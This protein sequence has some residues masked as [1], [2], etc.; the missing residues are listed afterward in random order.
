[1]SYGVVRVQK[2]TAGSV[3]GIEI[4]D[5]REKDHSHTNPDIDWSR[6]GENY[7]LHPAQNCNFRQAVN[8]RINQLD[9]Q[10]AV[11]KDA[12]V[13]AQI[14]VTSDS[15]FFQ[16]L[17]YSDSVANFDYDMMSLQG[18]RD[19][20]RQFFEDS[21]NFLRDRY[22]MENV[23]SAT[24]HMDE[25]TPHMHFN[26]VPVTADGRLSAKS[27]LTK[28]SLTEQQTAFYEN[29]GKNYD[30]MRGEP[31]ES[32]K[33]RSHLETAEFK[34]A[35][36]EVEDL[37]Q[38]KQ[39]LE[40]D[41]PAMRQEASESR[42]SVSDAREGINTL[43]AKKAALTGEINALENKK[44]TL[45]SNEVETISG[46]RTLTGGLKGVT[47]AEYEALKKTAAQVDR[48][49]KERNLALTKAVKAENKAAAAVQGAAMEIQAFKRDNNPSMAMRMA[50]AKLEMENA[51]LKKEIGTLRKAVDGIIAFIRREAPALIDK[52][53]D[54]IQPQR[55][56]QD[57][58][59]DR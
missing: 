39:D 42:Q 54:I 25:R 17:L 24:V 55:K 20:T 40:R 41:L 59:M 14:L 56:H 50:N 11:R 22:G 45:T 16:N 5:R 7:D 57:R 4:H 35:M 48:M 8:E 9:L 27:V 33:R 32:K 23:I 49:E 18:N 1:M 10:K 29:V 15:E 46:S 26:F 34:I 12:I 51:A 31:K 19:S 13:M 6:S 3:K 38:E 21:Y 36:Q 30:L 28:A 43:E 2:M 53:L 37:R 52:L 47:F 44:D 58:E